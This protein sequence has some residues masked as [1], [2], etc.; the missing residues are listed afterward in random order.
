MALSFEWKCE[1]GFRL[2]GGEGLIKGSESKWGSVGPVASRHVEEGERRRLRFFFEPGQRRG[3]W[4]RKSRRGCG[5]RCSLDNG[6]RIDE[7]GRYREASVSR[8]HIKCLTP[9]WCISSEVINLMG[10]YCSAKSTDCWFVPTYFSIFIP[11]LDDL[12]QHW[13]LAVVRFVGDC[14][15]WDS[16]P[17]VASQQ[18][19]KDYVE[20]VVDLLLLVFAAELKQSPWVCSEAASF[21]YFYPA[22]CTTEVNDY[23]SG[24]CVIRNMQFYGQR[25]YEGYNSGDQRM[26][27]A[28][29]VVNSP[30]N[31]CRDDVWDCVYLEKKNASNL[32]NR[33]GS[34]TLDPLLDRAGMRLKPRVPRR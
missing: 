14:E 32:Q 18:H 21:T 5:G 29:E 24:V 30:L 6:R 7:V 23:D 10:V 12:C 8:C 4:R 9:K 31:E 13:F 22:I 33:S 26:R 25:W 3:V 34:E 15:I 16:K 11:I 20:S 19:R 2:R 28:L 17:E 27:I 1:D